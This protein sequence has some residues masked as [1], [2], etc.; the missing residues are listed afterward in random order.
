[1]DAELKK[2]DEKT[3]TKPEE[4]AAKSAV[5]DSVETT[6]SYKLLL[7][8]FCLRSLHTYCRFVVVYSCH[9]RD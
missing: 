1:V 2:V 8:F 7:E 9:Q 6:G 5:P 3:A 4:K